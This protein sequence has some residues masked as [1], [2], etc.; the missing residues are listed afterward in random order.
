MDLHKSS[1][2][3]ARMNFISSQDLLSKKL[4]WLIVGS[5]CALALFNALGF[6]I[7]T[8]DDAYISLRYARN[9]VEGNG[10]TYN[11]GE[12]VEGFSNPTYVLIMALSLMMGSTSLEGIKI[13][14]FFSYMVCILGTIGLAL[15]LLRPKSRASLLTAL[16]GGLFFAVSIPLNFWPTAGLET[17][18][19]SMLLVISF[20][21]LWE[22]LRDRDKLP[23]SAC[24]LGITAITRPEAPILVLGAFLAAIQS[25]WKD[26]PKLVRWLGLFFIPTLGYLIFRLSYYGYLFANTYYQKGISRPLSSLWQYLVPW[27]SIE[28]PLALLGV[29][30][31]AILCKRKWQEAWFILMAVF[32]QCFFLFYVGSDWMPNH[33]FLVP[34]LPFFILA[35]MVGGGIIT[36]KLKGKA[37][38]LPIG[39]IVCLASLQISQTHSIYR[40]RWT[41]NA[42]EYLPRASNM[43]APASFSTPWSTRNILWFLLHVRSDAVVAY[44]DIGLLGWAFDYTIIDMAGL[45]DPVF[46]GAT[47]QEWPERFAY[48]K[49]RHPDWII[50]R[51]SS[52]NRFKYFKQQRWIAEQYTLTQD[53]HGSFVAKHNDVTPLTDQEILN[54]FELATR[55]EPHSAKMLFK[56]ALWTAAIGTPEQLDATCKMIAETKIMDRQAT[57]CENLKTKK[58]DRPEITNIPLAPKYKNIFA[59]F[60]KPTPKKS[61]TKPEKTDEDW[62]KLGEEKMKNKDFIGAVSDIT[63]TIVLN[64]QAVDAYFLRGQCLFLLKDF[65]GALRDFNQGLTI[66]PQHSRLLRQRGQLYL[67]T[68]KFEKAKNDFSSFLTLNPNEAKI[69][70][71]RAVAHI[72]SKNEPLDGA[73]DD[74]NRAI[75]INENLA[76]AYMQRS[77]LHLQN[78]NTDAA[79]KDY[80]QAAELGNNKAKAWL[81][82]HPIQD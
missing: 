4:F 17:S 48:L 51:T 35:I 12:N 82:N 67:K 28:W 66:Q 44:T 81:Q 57:M 46:S 58:I 32:S 65:S 11:P 5:V 59:H 42:I 80:Q 24:L 37:R 73:M 56:R 78:N 77:A 1:Q 70:L 33:R 25:H 62:L 41:N 27:L 2:Y 20:W 63:Q 14:G 7:F 38:W 76:V 29:C 52:G 36:E 31:L 71:Q 47:K 23:L 79:R 49:E 19:Y 13:V 40:A 8:I 74:L 55:R 21:R 72:K 15:E 9:L 10:L 60:S 26:K 69:Y 61:T 39:V 43:V 68:K 75:Q 54:N 64:P 18:F 34:M 16:A 22:E 3:N 50:I 6:W 45:T 53:K 30:G